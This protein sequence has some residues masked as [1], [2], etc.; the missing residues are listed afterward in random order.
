MP[1]LQRLETLDPR[2]QWP[3]EAADF[4]PWVSSAEGLQLIGDTLNLELET[5]SSS[6]EVPV[7]GLRA[8][9]VCVDTTDPDNS[10]VLIENQLATT[11]HAHIGQVLTYAAGLNAVTIIWVAVKFR[12]EHL[13]AIEWLNQITSERYR[14]FG[15]EIQLV[16][17]GN[18]NPAAMFS[19]VAKPND[20]SRDVRRRADSDPAR[21]N[22]NDLHREFW[23]ELCAYVKGNGIDVPIWKPLGQRWM[24]MRFGPPGAWLNAV[25]LVQPPSLRVEA[26]FSYEFQSAYFAALDDVRDEIESE[27][28]FQ[29]VWDPRNSTSRIFTTTTSDPRD[30]DDWPA[31]I[32]WFVDRL[33][34]FDRTLRH[35]LKDVDP[36]EW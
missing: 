9:V 35:R 3:D 19:V 29:L 13:A 33:Q 34:K 17:I 4:T 7:G 27:I 28:G 22:L 5:L 14:F 11:D 16:K 8:D 24:G 23:T 10:R 20:W 25:R 32:K 21:S 1:P 12:D 2:T 26:H 6:S 18:S 15:L 36:S 30:K 31:Q